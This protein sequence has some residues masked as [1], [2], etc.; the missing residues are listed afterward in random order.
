MRVL[1]RQQM[2]FADRATIDDHGVPALTLMQRAGHETALAIRRRFGQRARGRVSIFAGKGNNGG[3]GFVVA[4]ELAERAAA[5]RVFFLGRL[6]EIVGDARLCANDLSP[7]VPITPIPDEEAWRHYRFEALDAELL[8]DALFGTGLTRPLSGLAGSVVTDLNAAAAPIVAI[9][10]PSGLMADRTDVP[11]PAVRAALTVTFAVPKLPLVL[12]PA[13]D[14]VGE[15]VIADIGIAPDTIETLSGARVEYL[16]ARQLRTL[17]PTRKADSHKGLYGRVLIVGGSRG[18]IGAPAL[19]ARAA[20]RSGAGLVTVA[21]P[22][23]CWPIVASWTPET[24]TDPLPETADGT[25]SEQ[26]V[27][28]VLASDATILAIGPG[29]G[30]SASTT[31]FVR[32][33]VTRSQLPL[34][35]DADALNALAGHAD[36]LRSRNAPQVVLTPHPGEMARLTGLSVAEV[37][38]TRLSVA[39][40]FAV[41]HSVYVVLKGHRTVIATPSGDA[42]INPTGNPGMAT[43]GAGDVLTGVIAGWLATGQPALEASTLGVYLHGAAGDLAAARHGQIGL[44]ASDIIDHLGA[45]VR[46]LAPPSSSGTGSGSA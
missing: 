20:L 12:T 35:L 2:Q 6:D 44:I 42:F 15:L 16:E 7:H 8:V 45:A 29:L 31:A 43:A 19:T 14:H 3:D 11:G 24:M 26:A 38:R 10:L 9:D 34:V 13:C 41:S 30:R 21:P 40:A 33:L 1:D 28:H 46:A 37:Q 22:S 4:R 18:K 39:R 17:I 25:V 32:Q 23:S 5:V 36:L 27:E